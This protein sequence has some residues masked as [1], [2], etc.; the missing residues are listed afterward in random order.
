MNNKIAIA[1]VFA[2]IV[3]IALPITVQ[4]GTIRVITTTS[5][6]ASIAKK[7]GGKLVEVQSL[8][9]GTRD[10]HFLQAKPTYIMKARKA[11]LFIR[12]GMELEIGYEPV[13][14]NS[15]RNRNI[16]V[17]KDGHLDL[18]INTVKLEVPTMKIDRSMGDVHPMGNPH[19]WLDPY[20][21][22]IMAQDITQRLIKL[23]PKN[24]KTYTQNLAAFKKRLDEAMF[25]KKAVET[26]G[27]DDL[28]KVLI[29]GTIDKHL[30]EKKIESA[31]W[32]GLL[33][34]YKG[35]GIVSQHRSWNYLLNRFGL[36]LAIE[37]ESKPGVP[38][39]PRHLK[40]VV[41]TVKAEKVQAIIVE[42][43]YGTKAADFVASRTNATV[44]VCANAVGG[45]PQASDYIAMLDNAIQSLAKALQKNTEGKAGGKS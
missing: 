42:P 39:S 26:I 9:D 37:M 19:Y 16:Q 2:L 44:I 3:A 20:N 6:I 35:K 40:K 11:D 15:C 10:P 12:I 25:G 17:G 22:R 29:E 1:L 24:K 32:Y 36:K 38:P 43:F 21:G 23:D 41:E 45:Q 31:G 18:S 34:P 4:A 14:L 5:D 7:V 30:K 33:L 28:W 8:N 27:G 13:I